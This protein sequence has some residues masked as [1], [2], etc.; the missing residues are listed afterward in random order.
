MLPF[1]L[2]QVNDAV[3]EL[4]I[5]EEDFEGLRSSI[6]THDNFDQVRG[7]AQQAAAWTRCKSRR[8]LVMCSFLPCPAVS[9]NHWSEFVTLVK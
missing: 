7:R 8:T 5:D 6:T 3:N 1:L 4:L 2:L 9:G